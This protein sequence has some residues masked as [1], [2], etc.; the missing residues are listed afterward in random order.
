MYL[1]DDVEQLRL[2]VR[3]A[4]V[5]VDVHS[6]FLVLLNS[7]LYRLHVRVLRVQLL[8]VFLDVCGE[9]LL[10][11]SMETSVLRLRINLV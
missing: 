3:F 5:L 4:L 11:I 10:T 7:D 9:C 8:S 6:Y 2:S 1:V